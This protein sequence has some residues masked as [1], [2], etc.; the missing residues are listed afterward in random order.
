MRFQHVLLSVALLGPGRAHAAQAGAG[1]ELWRL[2]AVTLTVPPALATGIAAA[3]WNPA[4]G[5]TGSTRLGLDL[6]ETPEAVGAT[7]VLAALRVPVRPV[8]GLGL[9]YARMGL[10][11]LVRTSDSP[12]PVGEAIPY[13][14]QSAGIIWARGVGRSSVGARL[15]YYDTNLDGTRI[16]RWTLDAGVTHSF[17]ERLRVAAATRGLRRLRRDPAQ[18]LYA[19][20]EGRL[21]RGTLWRS[22]SGTLIARY[23]VTAGHPGGADH[24]L[25]AGLDVGAAVAVDLLVAREATYGNAAWRG[26]AGLRFA[27]G[28]YR[29]T[30]ARDGGIS[31][32]GS[33]F[34]VGLEA[35]IQ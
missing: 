11:D 34:R 18:D 22:T 9:A 27:M 13:Y 2:A 32:L 7:G 4:Q 25:G 20:V 12:D 8:G 30:F 3:F 21:W 31:D 15:T 5:E 17:G 26:A 14:A 29:M 6:I 35:R 10:S 23:G 19:G 24:Q 28:R 33:A 16:A 1:S